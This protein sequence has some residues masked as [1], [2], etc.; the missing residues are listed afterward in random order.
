MVIVGDIAVGKTSLASRFVEDK[1][2]KNHI[3][4]VGVAYFTKTLVVDEHLT[5]KFDI[6]DTAGQERYRSINT[7]Y[8]R[9]AAAAVI[10]FDLTQR[11][12]FDAMK[13]Q[14]LD[15]IRSCADSNIILVIAGNKSDMKEN[16]VIPQEE[17]DA[18]CQ[19]ENLL[20]VE[21]SAL[22]GEGVSDLFRM[23]AL[24]VQE[25]MTSDIKTGFQLVEMNTETT[26]QVKLEGTPS[27]KKE[28]S[29]TNEEF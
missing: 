21:T 24:R 1:F 16:R 3:A 12:T 17:I 13:T 25:S 6:W 2:P 26:D 29:R 27:K 15:S 4:S 10:V 11:S 8:Y 9:G 14:W 22:T 7:L 18:F 28:G 19:K 23:I 5:V 20:Y